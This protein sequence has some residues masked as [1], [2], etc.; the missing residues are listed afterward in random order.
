[1]PIT[2]LRSH[3]SALAI[4]AMTVG[5]VAVPG[6]ATAQAADS[7]ERR[8]HFDIAAGPLLQALRR[9]SEITGVQL[10]YPSSV[11]QGLSS[12][13][14][15]G[16]YTAR[17]ALARLAAGTGL[18]PVM[19]NA[20][21]AT[22]EAPVSVDGAH[23]LGSV[24]IEGAQS[25]GIVAVDG[26][27]AGAG[28]N[29]SSDP[30]ATEGTGSFTTNGASVASKTAQ[31]LKD[32][33]QSVS[34][35]TQERIEQQNLTDVTTAV[36]NLAGVT[37]NQ[38]SGIES[39][40]ISRGF[41]I[42]TYQIDGAAPQSL[43][44]AQNVGQGVN[45]QANQNLAEFDNVQIVRGSDGLFGGGGD[46]G[47]VISLNR[48]RPLD[49]NQLTMDLNIGSW[50]NYRGQVDVTGPLAFDGALR[51]RLVLEGKDRDYFYN[52]AHTRTGFVYGVIEGD[53]GSNTLVRVGG[54]YE[55]Q[56]NHGYNAVGLPRYI[57]GGD[58]HLPRST[59]LC[60]TWGQSDSRT[61][62]VFGALEHRFN[63]AWHLKVNVTRTDRETNK[64]LPYFVGNID[65]GS[66]RGTGE[67]LSYLYNYPGLSDKSFVADA[68]VSGS[69]LLLGY[70][71]NILFGIDYSRETSFIA[72]GFSN[73]GE[74]IPDFYNFNPAVL[75]PRPA[76]PAP[77]TLTYVLQKQYGGY[78][79][80]NL[81]FTKALHVTGGARL[82]Y[83]ETI[84]SQTY[85]FGNFTTPSHTSWVP[86]PFASV[87]YDVTNTV[88]LY[89][90]YADIYKSQAAVFDPNGQSLPPLRGVTYEGG[91]KGAFRGG[92]LN[93]SI[94]YY[95]TKQRNQAIFVLGSDRANC[96][97]PF[98]CEVPTGEYISKGVDVEVAG[99]VAPGW[100]VQAG[101]T[102]NDNA[103]GPA[104]LAAYAQ[105]GAFQTQQPAHQVKLWTAYT[106]AGRLHAWT[107]GGGLRLDSAR[108]TSGYACAAGIDPTTGGCLADS[109]PFNFT[110]NLYAVADLRVGYSINKHWQAALNVTNIGDTR[111]FS[112]AGSTSSSNFYGE[113]RAFLLS[114]HA[115]Y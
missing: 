96:A 1:M 29:G 34:V 107:V 35:L 8:F 3:V 12:P 65:S 73:L 40:Y 53:I 67:T 9:Y 27:G 111:Y 59:C 90:S 109:V 108:Y 36:N 48:K 47:G 5:L 105:S 75:D 55:R 62:E 78:G 61:S 13:G 77:D 24:N 37:L 10:V 16:D 76:L 18:V 23:T 88:S 14:V 98:N 106:P 95:Y 22:L 6:A 21:S 92:K 43:S 39:S 74:A 2:K 72:Q 44:V 91:V 11:A 54:S 45:P 114:V 58:L 52:V 70:K 86:T 51:G 30:T 99:E 19:V 112:T 63:D 41:T 83:Y 80:L 32:T 71:Q 84:L 4:A 50:N 103:Y 93:A 69:L 17:E 42:G 101:Y 33:T 94:A 60:A 110:Q 28:A 104:Y 15:T 64:I 31:S 100:Q 68:N 25:S 87:R 79:T 26:F 7:T 56:D 46:P 81:Q 49:H 38:T 113:P 89:A 66:A 102:Y 97:N 85:S 20:T 115:I 82:S 57:D